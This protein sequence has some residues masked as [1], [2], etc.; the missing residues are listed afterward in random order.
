MNTTSQ[1]TVKHDSMR[2][3]KIV[4]NS[5]S[6]TLAMV[7]VALGLL[8]SR[9]NAATTLSAADQDFIQ[10]AA[11]GGMTEVKLGELAVQKGQRDDVKQF[12]QMR[13]N[14]TGARLCKFSK[15]YFVKTANIPL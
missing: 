2:F 1:R 9:A 13:C 15:S 6:A 10:A 14:S 4:F 11:Q 8:V 5:A 12:G 7:L 3:V